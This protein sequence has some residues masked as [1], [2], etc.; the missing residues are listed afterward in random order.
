MAR[1]PNVP[2]A[3]ASNAG[4]YSEDGAALSWTQRN[5]MTQ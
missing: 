4:D 2:I 1:L 3:A 5:C